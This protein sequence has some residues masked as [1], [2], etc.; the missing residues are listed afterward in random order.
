MSKKILIVDDDLESLKLVGLMLQ[1]RGYEIIAAHS[2]GQALSKA[3][4]EN[5]DLVILD[6]MMPGVDGYQVCQ[7]LRADPDTA[8]LPVIMFTAKT[9]VGDKVAGFQAGAD[10]YL[11]KPIHPNELVSHVEALLQRAEQARAEVK[12]T[13]KARTIGLIGAKGGV[14]VSTLA[15]NLA[16]ALRQHLT[17]PDHRQTATRVSIVDMHAGWGGVALLL[18][19]KPAGGWGALAQYATQSL[20]QEIIERYLVSH[21]SGLFYWPATPLP[22][23]MSDLPQEMIEPVLKYMVTAS[24]YL[25]F[26]LGN[27]LSDAVQH[28]IGY[29]DVVLVV[30]EPEPLCLALTQDVLGKMKTFEPALQ[31]IRLVIVER[32]EGDASHSSDE[33]AHTL[34][35]AL[36][37]VI[38]PAADLARR[39]ARQGAPLVWLEPEAPVAEQIQELVQTL[40]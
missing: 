27:V 37:G 18:G 35:I 6:I 16:A 39:A 10:D 23:G 19:Q 26:D 21:A 20:T 14:G 22:S 33:I 28:A 30:V 12:A 34:G 31:D 17:Q 25:F 11:T 3:K 15:V 29:C 1:R 40:L 38:Q 9:L 2:G 36:A 5:P 7:Q 13:P 32:L 4:T 8:L 24:D